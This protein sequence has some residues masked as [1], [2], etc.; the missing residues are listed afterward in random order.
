MSEKSPVRTLNPEVARKIAAGEVIDRP[1]AVVREL[2]DNAIDSNADSITVEI[3][4][5]GIE[6]VRIIDNGSGMTKEDLKNCAR[7][8]STSKI[9]TETDLLNLSTLGFRGEALA[10]IAA[11]SRLSITSGGWKMMASLT[12]D[13]VM[14]KTAEYEGTIVQSEGLF[15]NFP[16]RRLFL[17]RNATEGSLCKSTFIEKCLPHPEKAFRFISDGEVKLD[18]PKNQSLKDRYMEATE[19]RENRSLFYQ[20]EGRSQGK[21]PDWSFKIIIGEPGVRR[22]NKKDIAIFV[23]GRKIQEYALV[24]AIEYGGQGYF[25]NGSFP[26]AAAFI[27]VNPALVD[28]N[29][30]PAK[31]EVKFKDISSLHHGISST[32]RA[33][34][35]EYTGSSMKG[36]AETQKTDEK[37]SVREGLSTSAS[38]F[39]SSRNHP[40]AGTFDFGTPESEK[41]HGSEISGKNGKGIEASSENTITS[42]GREV[43]AGIK[44]PGGRLSDIYAKKTESPQKNYGIQG[45]IAERQNIFFSKST[46]E[47]GLNEGDSSAGVDFTQKKSG[48]SEIR[49][50]MEKIIGNYNGLREELAVENESPPYSPK[51]GIYTDAENPSESRT[52]TYENEDFH[53]LGSAL[54]TFIVAEKGKALYIIDKHAAHE[55]MIF[56]RIMEEKDKRQNLLIPYVVETKDENEDRYLESI[57]EELSKIGFNCRQAEEGRWEFTSL[58]ERW[59]GSEED[60]EHAIFDRKV[61][62]KDL[63][64]SMAAMTA[65]KAAVKDGWTLLDST[66]EEIARG[67]LAL[68]D[69]HCPHGRPCYFR[70]TREELFSLVRRTE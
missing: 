2:M 47:V 12:E 5:G 52:K 62:P 56:D 29:I 38:S 61:S 33:F 24:Q 65:C 42:Y 10:S 58:N 54:G 22:S 19:T 18:L 60:L 63:I 64:Y 36:V 46:D 23:N 59:K 37:H 34:F 44:F 26:V 69:P 35:S 31:K 40:S 39:F 7:P 48:L 17:K 27:Q 14:E 55:R 4:G 9:S 49:T 45:K 67:A 70:L 66:A 1:N 30:H 11:V 25:P 50:E 32:L 53:F 3:S 43:F 13:H 41:K 57:R 8:H 20:V 28:F 51:E 16:A 21:N 15:E 6:K 68:K